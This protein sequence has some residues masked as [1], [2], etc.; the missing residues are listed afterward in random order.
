MEEGGGSF[1]GGWKGL[2]IVLGVFVF[3]CVCVRVERV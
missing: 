3:V 2:I 1:V